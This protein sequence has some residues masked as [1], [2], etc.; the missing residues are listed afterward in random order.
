[1]GPDDSWPRRSYPVFLARGALEALGGRSDE[2][3]ARAPWQ[4][5]A[6]GAFRVNHLDELS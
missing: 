1:L 2:L 3:G 4:R 6:D 5:P